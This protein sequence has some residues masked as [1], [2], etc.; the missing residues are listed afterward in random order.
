MLKAFTDYTL[1]YATLAVAATIATLA[2]LGGAFRADAHCPVF[3]GGIGIAGPI[4]TFSGSTLPEGKFALGV[5]AEIAA[6]DSLSDPELDK[7]VMDNGTAH[8]IRRQQLYSL[9]GA[10][11]VGDDLTVGLSLPYLVR[12]GIKAVHFDSEMQ[13]SMLHDI[14]SSDG[15][16]DLALFAQYRPV[17]KLYEGIDLSLIAGLKAPTGVTGNRSHGVVIETEH[18]PGSGSWDPILGVA[19]SKRVNRLSLH[20]TGLY[21]VA[22]RGARDTNLG[23]RAQVTLAGVYRVGGKENYGDCDQI[24]EYFY[25][26]SRQHW[27]I[28]LVLETNG[29][30][31][32]KESV[33]GRR[34]GSSGGTSLYLAPGIRVIYDGRYSASFSLGLPVYQD[35]NGSQSRTDYRASAAL[36]Y[37]F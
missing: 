11:G 20:A 23:D 3:S 29:S 15:L 12:G 26:E 28:D 25:P 36:A 1:K 31:Q 17:H 5:R 10:Y 30:W 32:D 37:A 33:A 14:G 13:M 9:N 34:D 22:T 27:L 35:L 24:Y 19:L 4:N 21:T 7:A 8:S 2:T 6:F 16:G 18:Q